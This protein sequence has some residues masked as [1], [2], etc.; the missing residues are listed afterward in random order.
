MERA[1]LAVVY[2]HG[3]DDE[4]R[5]LRR[6]LVQR[7]QEIADLRDRQRM[8]E[9]L[10]ATSTRERDEACWEALC[11]AGI[12]MGG[13]DVRHLVELY[14]TRSHWGIVEGVYAANGSR[15]V[16]G[17]FNFAPNVNAEFLVP[18][19]TLIRLLQNDFQNRTW[20]PLPQYLQMLSESGIFQPREGG[21]FQR[22]FLAI[23][24]RLFEE[25]FDTDDEGLSEGSDMIEDL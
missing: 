16:P 3:R 11:Q 8:L 17:P 22:H 5:E 19:T 15:V 23:T 21:H 7:N 10:V 25:Y 20:R 2:D 1:A 6:L 14:I 4:L 24:P 9:Q 13:F 12:R 18:E